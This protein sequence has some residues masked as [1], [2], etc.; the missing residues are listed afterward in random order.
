MRAM[1]TIPFPALGLAVLV[2]LAAASTSVL[3][4]W[5][6]SG[7]QKAAG[8]RSAPLARVWREGYLAGVADERTSTAWDVPGYGPNRNNP[9]PGSEEGAGDE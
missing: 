8:L 3:L 9:Y 6:F 4:A 5:F 1:D 2:V 7:R